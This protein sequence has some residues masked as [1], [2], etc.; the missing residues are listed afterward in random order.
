MGVFTRFLSITD[1][2]VRITTLNG[3]YSGAA[4]RDRMPEFR[5]FIRF[6]IPDF[7]LIH[8]NT[9]VKCRNRQCVFFVV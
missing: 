7:Y 8:C 1:R 9:L 6:I 2:N 5:L 4:H 3:L